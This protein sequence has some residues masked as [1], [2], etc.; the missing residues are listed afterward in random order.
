MN[1][2]VAS[3][4]RGRLRT[5]VEASV[6]LLLTAL[7]L[8]T[9]LLSGLV[10]PC[11]VVG[12]SMAEALLGVHRQVVCADCG[13]RFL[14]GAD[15]AGPPQAVCPNCGYAANDVATLPDLGG[16]RLLID[17][18]AFSLRPPRRWE[19]VALRHPQQADEILV[20][21][22]VGLPGELLEIRDGDVYV[23]G[24]IQR[25][26]LEQQHA[27]AILVHDSDYRPTLDPTTAPRWR[28]QRPENGWKPAAA[29]FSHAA[30]A[31]NG[32][33]DWL[34]YHHVRRAAGNIA[35]RRPSRSLSPG[36]RPGKTAA[37][38]P[39]P[40]AQRAN[41]SAISWPVGSTDGQG[42]SHF[43]GRCPGLGELSPFG[44]IGVP[45]RD[46]ATSGPAV[47]LPPQ[48]DV[49]QTG[50]SAPPS[51]PVTSDKEIESP[52][53]DLCGYNQSQPR[54]EEDVHAVADLLL[55]FRLAVLSG[56]GQFC[57]RASDA[58]RPFEIRLQF[59]ENRPR[60][61]TYG[62]YR[63]DEPIPRRSGG[64]DVAIGEHLVEVSLID[65][66]FLLAFDRQTVT[67]WPYER[68]SQPSLTPLAIGV[69]GLEAT[70]RSLRV[71]R[72][73][74]YAPSVCPGG[75]ASAAGSQTGLASDEYYVVGDNS[76][77]SDDSRSW[78]DRGAVA[79][80]L[81]IGKPLVAIP[82]V[83][84]TPWRGLSFQVPNPARIRYIQ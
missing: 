70:V 10:V 23:N 24:Q 40:S 5:A 29:G 78:T 81:L 12:G 45:A 48:H 18:A 52:V 73:V 60:R 7:S 27:L 53:T 13:R 71:Y 62:L 55:S 59:D 69:A 64:W 72:D 68:C 39:M 14:Y 56:R 67:A 34:V 32:P 8:E 51:S 19:I 22:V 20:K 1:V 31:E 15:E 82:S 63:G 49:G 57:V 79:A 11:R 21:R 83:K 36:Q 77:I 33:I 75:V 28:P 41:R 35:G 65:R 54:R 43:P 6:W 66:Q 76:P 37:I 3:T 9:W 80:K 58:G 61:F 4:R 50:M 38:E 2:A 47:Q 84:I 16:D 74:Y 46:V 17:R 44:A 42:R 30:A 26:S 25:K